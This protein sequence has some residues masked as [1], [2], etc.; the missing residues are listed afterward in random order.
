MVTARKESIEETLFATDGNTGSAFDGSGIAVRFVCN[1]GMMRRLVGILE[2]ILF[3]AV[4]LQ[5][6]GRKTG[7][8]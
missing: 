6:I 5:F 8:F 2:I 7:S 4:Q 1:S 3:L